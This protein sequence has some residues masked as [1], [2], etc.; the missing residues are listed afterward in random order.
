MNKNSTALFNSHL[1][2]VGHESAKS[3][4]IV[5]GDKTTLEFTLKDK[6]AEPIELTQATGKAQIIDSDR[7]VLVAVFDVEVEG[8]KATFSLDKAL[9]ADD[10]ELY[11][12][13]GDY[14]FPSRED[15]FLLR[16]I[17]AY[18]V[19]EDINLDD[20][21]TIDI[22]VDALRADVIE[23][24][25]PEVGSYIDQILAENPDRFKGEKGDKFTRDDFTDEEWDSLRGEDATPIP[26]SQLGTEE[27]QYLRG[28]SAYEVAQLNGYEGTEEEWLDS[29][30]LHFSELTPEEVEQLKLRV[31]DVSYDEAGNTLIEFSDGEIATVNKGDKGDS[32]KNL[33][34][35][36]LSPEQIAE[37]RENMAVRPPQT[38]TREEYDALESYDPHTIYIVEEA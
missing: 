26:P 14:Y 38:Y 15:S 36:D 23:A 34:Y 6:N 18:D 22:V 12:K 8:S 11:I 9:P 30:A 24:I 17:N 35:E 20:I 31:A 37:L 32:G 21:Q 4:T 10:Y 5:Q 13:I 27:L 2:L 25:K 1:S 28:Q 3:L 33:T 19:V 16:V 7:D 29:L